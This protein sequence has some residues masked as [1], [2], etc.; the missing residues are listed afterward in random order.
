VHELGIA[1]SIV[2]GVEEELTRHDGARV[3]KV[4]LR[5]GALSG[6]SKD[7]LL[8]C[9]DVACEGSKLQGSTLQ[10]DDNSS[11]SDLEVFAL[12]LTEQED[13]PIEANAL[14]REAS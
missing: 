1:L 7:A 5:L 11:G 6:V 9:Y 13:D 12:E 10:I 4:H 3:A 14:S 8:F 2:E